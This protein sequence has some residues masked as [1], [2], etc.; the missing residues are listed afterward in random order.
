MAI[1]M[2]KQQIMEINN[3][4]KNNW[5]FDTEFFVFLSM[6]TLFKKVK[7]D[8]TGYF[9]FRLFYN[10]QN[11]ITLH[12]KRFYYEDNRIMEREATSIILNKKVYERE[13]V[14]RLLDMTE[15]LTDEQLLKLYAETK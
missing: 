6:K 4:C 3:K 10:N 15:K 5:E 8:D 1:S 7:I 11:Q 2:T 14:S 13:N 12:I 9:E